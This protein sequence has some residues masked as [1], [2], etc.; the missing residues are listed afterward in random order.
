MTT[1]AQAVA[2][3]KA[4]ASAQVTL[5]PCYWDKD[6]K[7]QLPSDPAPFAF[8]YVELDPAALIAIGGGRGGNLMRAEGELVVLVFVP[9]D[10]GLEEHARLGEHAAAAF[11]SF[12][13]AHIACGAVSPQ[14][15]VDGSSLKPPG[16][17]SEIEN[18]AVT[19]VAVPFWFDFIG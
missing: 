16:L 17:D 4:R 6:Q 8:A 19:V 9:R 18:Y 3:L 11:R 5:L 14:P 13:D 12:R 15:A 10:W 1:L 2:S 7:P